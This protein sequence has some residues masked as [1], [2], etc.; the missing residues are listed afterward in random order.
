MPAALSPP[1]AALLYAPDGYDT[2]RPR[3][4]GR[5]AAGEGFLGG[6]V[7]H[8]G[9][10]RLVALTCAEADAEAFRRHVAALGAGVPAETI[11]EE[12]FHRLAGIG[13]L[14]LPGPGLGPY[15]WRRRR[16][17]RAR[18]FS[19]IG[20]TH[21]IASA[22][23]MD[24]ILDSL[25]A[26]VQEWDAVVCTSRAAQGAVRRQ[27]SLQAAWLRERLGATR[28]E[29]P[30]LPVIPLGV[31]C[32]ALAPDLAERAAWRARLGATERDVVVLHHGRLSFH[33]KA[34]PLP[35][36]AGLGRAAPP[37]GGRVLLVLSGWFADDHQRRAF[38]AQAAAFAPGVTL[39]LVERP[40]SG[41]TIRNAA[42]IF[43][44]LSDNIQESFGLAPVEAMAAGLPVVGTDWDGLRDTVAHGETGLL[45]PT[46]MAGPMA[47]LAAR[48]DDGLDSYDAYIAGVAQFTAVDVPAAAAAFGALVA[49][50]ALRARMGAA[51]RRRAQERFDWASVIAAWRNLW[52]EM[53]RLRH[54]ARA[55][56]APPRRGEEPV[57]H[58]PDPSLMFA[59]YP[60]RR[61]T[62]ETVLALVPG[63]SAAA[64]LA[65]LRAVVGLPGVTPRRDLLP[66]LDAFELVLGRLGQG[67]ARVAELVAELP[68]ARAWR[69]Q[70]ALGWMLKAELV[71][72]A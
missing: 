6:M 29:G 5:H 32:A 47:D 69:M 56:R 42:D 10:D 18:G 55:E 66:G 48:H 31:D 7:R 61:L 35:M 34:Q 41:T 13:C 33:A 3:L 27:L 45:V 60:T 70:R 59:D 38:A 16:T 46:T 4:M 68:P 17:G 53:A 14:L 37:P 26:P 19:L 40:E 2:S 36:L 57:P 44:L 15:A 54:A 30:Q 65:R 24:S 12:Q 72:F 64:A 49:D 52:E 71:R 1:A 58:R 39:R 11:P 21:T 9:F 22:G 67:P 8:A 25:V 43:V 23:A 62:P 50:P 20:L 28:I 51:G 63:E